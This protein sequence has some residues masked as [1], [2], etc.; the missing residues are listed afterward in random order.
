MAAGVTRIAADSASF[1][2][3]NFIDPDLL[4]A[5]SPNERG[6]SLF[7]S[8]DGT[9]QCGVW[10]CDTYSERLPSYPEDELY[11]LIEGSVVVTVDGEEP[12]TFAAGDAFVIRQGTMCTLEFRGPFRKL[13]MTHDHTTGRSVPSEPG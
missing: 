4:L 8:D 2:P 9:V 13:W 5:G 1:V 10:A 12:E 7:A 11:V 3:T 6:V